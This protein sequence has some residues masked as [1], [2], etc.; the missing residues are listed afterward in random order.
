VRK[1]FLGLVLVAALAVPGVA[2]AGGK[3]P[4]ICAQCND[5]GT[6]WTGCAQITSEESGGVSYIAHW[7]HYLVVNF[8]KVRGTITSLAIVAHGCDS[9]GF[10]SCSPGPAWVTSGGVGLG[11]AS[12]EGRA[13]YSGT[14]AG[15]P[16]NSTSVVHADVAIG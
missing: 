7:R 10:A 5:G 2:A 13:T 9:E 6:G 3:Q 1:V 8:C 12:V 14:V 11:W 4:V 16:F 15:S